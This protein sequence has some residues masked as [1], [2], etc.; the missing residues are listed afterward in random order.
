MDDRELTARLA[1]AIAHEITPEF[2][3]IADAMYERHESGEILNVTPKKGGLAF[4]AVEIPQQLIDLFVTA[5]PIIKFVASI[6]L[7]GFVPLYLSNRSSN[8]HHEAIMEMLRLQEEKNSELKAQIDVLGEK[9]SRLQGMQ[10]ESI[11]DA[12]SRA[13]ANV[14]LAGS[15]KDNNDENEN[16]NEDEREKEDEDE[17]EKEDE[18]EREKED[19]DES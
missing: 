13:L 6:G 1:V 17:R 7:G 11:R 15:K 16:E 5:I 18:D 14:M 12:I 10:E 3:Y 2:E 8:Q 19:E 9:Y 4:G